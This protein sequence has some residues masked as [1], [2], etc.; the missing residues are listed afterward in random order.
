LATV[1]RYVLALHVGPRTLEMA[2]R[3]V[4]SAACCCR[5]GAYPLFLIDDHL[6][7]PSALLQVFGRICHGRRRRRRGRRKQPRLKAPEG[8]LVGVVHKLRDA[9][10]NLQGVSTR[11][12]FG[13]RKAIRQRI[14]ALKI[15]SQINTAHLE[16][17]NGTLRT[18]QGRLARRTRMVS[19]QQTYLQWALGLWSD[20]YNWTR[21]H[22]SLNGDTPAMRERL[23]DH[24]WSVADY[25]VYP[26]HAS[27]LQKEIWQEE[28]EK[29]LES[30]LQR[31]KRRKP[32]PIL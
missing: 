31:Y 28:L 19:R 15:G 4:A 20:L 10:G 22:R 12:L 32:L 1:S 18:Q 21:K 25:M 30:E 6:P 11:A 14:A 27:D 29:C 8:L 2:A 26:V 9:K 23:T 3:L 5:P 16:R 24:V 17:F 7:Y 13:T